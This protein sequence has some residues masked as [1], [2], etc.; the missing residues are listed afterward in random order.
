MRPKRHFAL[1]DIFPMETVVKKNIL[2]IPKISK[3]LPSYFSKKNN[4]EVY[5]CGCWLGNKTFV[6]GLN[7][8]WEK[9]NGCRIRKFS[10]FLCQKKTFFSIFGPPLFSG[11]RPIFLGCIPGVSPGEGGF[12]KYWPF[13]EISRI[14]K[15]NFWDFA[16]GGVTFQ[17]RR[18]FQV[19]RWGGLSE[20]FFRCKIFSEMP[21]FF[22]GPPA[23][24]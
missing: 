10:H 14:F 21:I 13:F 18:N 19:D 8:F 7:F 12:L 2:K 15:V 17:K 16:K 11:R 22:F 9:K 23:R 5:V 3:I 4:S 1:K 24:K 6:G 20:I